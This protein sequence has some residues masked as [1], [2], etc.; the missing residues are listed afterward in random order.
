MN[1]YSIFNWIYALEN[2]KELLIIE[3]NTNS[4]IKRVVKKTVE[5]LIFS[6]PML[7]DFSKLLFNKNSAFSLVDDIFEIKIKHFLPKNTNLST[8]SAECRAYI[9]ES[10]S[11]NNVAKYHC[12]YSRIE[13]CSLIDFLD[14]NPKEINLE[15]NKNNFKILTSK[16]SEKLKG[17]YLCIEAE[18]KI[19]FKEFKQIVN[20]IIL[21]IGFLSGYLYKK[22][23]YYFQSNNVDF[24]QSEFF[25]RNQNKRLNSYQPFLK[26]PQNY[27]NLYDEKFK[28]DDSYKVKYSSNIS[29]NNFLKLFHLVN[30]NPKY[31]SAIRMLFEVISSSFVSKHSIL[32]IVLETIALEVRNNNNSEHINKVIYRKECF[33]ELQKIKDKIPKESYEILFEGI[34]NIDVKKAKNIVDYELA[35][36]SL[37]INLGE[38]DKKTLK[39]RNNLHHGRII[40]NL[41]T[42]DSEEDFENLEIEYDYFSYKLYTLICK[43]ILKQID[44]EGYLVNH[45]K[46][47]TRNKEIV[48]V[49]P[50]FTKL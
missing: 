39:R 1:L 8:Q 38:S 41:V 29:E 13:S 22:E 27:S 48:K 37:K 11:F 30:D 25:Y 16:L 43:L 46:F 36:S 42:I 7:N 12:Y 18:N 4:Q 5:G 21:S 28:K 26:Y 10:K 44:F 15:I 40:D 3:E 32:F 34:G 33:E 19:T 31:Y 20:S 47:H 17:D 14:N 24:E 6:L 35:F 45:A 50:Y 2:G 23:E 9:F 49:E